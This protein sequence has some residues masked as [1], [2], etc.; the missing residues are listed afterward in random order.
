MTIP[1]FLVQT[2]RLGFKFPWPLC[3]QKSSC[4]AKFYTAV[5][6]VTRH[7][8]SSVASP[9]MS[10]QPPCHLQTGKGSQGR[11]PVT[12]STVSVTLQFTVLPLPLHLVFTATASILMNLSGNNVDV[13][14]TYA[15]RCCSI[16][17]STAVTC[18]ARNVANFEGGLGIFFPPFSDN[19]GISAEQLLFLPP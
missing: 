4:P 9:Q 8:D 7:S 15:P 19:T 3:F 10:P 18:S 13:M 6:L 17:A 16:S 11:L 2:Q 12:V 5:T 1:G 14:C